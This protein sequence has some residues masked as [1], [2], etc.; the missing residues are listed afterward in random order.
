[1]IFM[2]R[3]SHLGQVLLRERMP[4]PALFLNLDDDQ[5]SDEEKW[6]RELNVPCPWPPLE[7]SCW[8]GRRRLWS[9]S[10]VQVKASLRQISEK[11]F[12]AISE[13]V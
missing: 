9:A 5:A 6:E 1:M 12:L 13:N 2:A 7:P 4:L 10:E 8:D 11:S 3:S